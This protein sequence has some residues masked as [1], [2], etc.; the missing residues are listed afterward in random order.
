MA[1]VDTVLNHDYCSVFLPSSKEAKVDQE[2]PFTHFTLFSKD[3]KQW[4]PGNMCK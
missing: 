3:K 4:T 2:K 1:M